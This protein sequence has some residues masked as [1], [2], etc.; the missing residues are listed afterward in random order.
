MSTSSSSNIIFILYCP[1]PSVYMYMASSSEVLLRLK[2]LYSTLHCKPWDESFLGHHT[3][4]LG[5]VRVR[6]RVRVKIGVKIVLVGLPFHS[7]HSAL[8]S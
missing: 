2:D 1:F 8:G 4:P 7:M 6:V 3:G 5:G